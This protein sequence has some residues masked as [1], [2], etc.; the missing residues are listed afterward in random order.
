MLL[1]APVARSQRRKLD[2]EETRRTGIDRLRLVRSTIPAVTHVDYSAR[3]Q[4]VGPD[5]NPTLHA[6][7][8]EFDARTG[9]P[10]LVNTS[11][12]VR[13]EPIVCTPRDAYN[14]FLRTQMDCLVLGNFVLRKEQQ[15]ALRMGRESS[16][17]GVWEAVGAA[18]VGYHLDD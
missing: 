13:G 2:E 9:C 11:F 5:T 12:N 6:L 4:T 14:C 18:P 1:V 3:I 15:R 17:R 7:L 8:A 16:V 10:V